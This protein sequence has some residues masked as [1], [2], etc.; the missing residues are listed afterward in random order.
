M[1]ILHIDDDFDI[2]QLAQLGLAEI[3][4]FEVLQ[5]SSGQEALEQA[6]AFAPDMILIDMMMPGLD[7]PET[8]EHLRKLDGLEATPAAFMTARGANDA[9]EVAGD[10]EVITKPFD[11]L[12]IADEVKEIWEKQRA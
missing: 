5:C 6:Q 7:G 10:T 1:R 3:G 2:R 12:T 4:G 9:K 11:P 8:L